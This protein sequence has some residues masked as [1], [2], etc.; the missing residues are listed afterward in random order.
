MDYGSDVLLERLLG[1]VPT[2]IPDREIS[3]TKT[4]E[5]WMHLI[6]SAHKKVLKKEGKQRLSFDP[7]VTPN[8]PAG[9]TH[10]K[11]AGPTQGE[12]GRGRLRPAKMAFTLLAF[13]RGLQILWLVPRRQ[14]AS[15]LLAWSLLLLAYVSWPQVPVCQKTTSSWR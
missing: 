13:L 14:C 3:S 7:W 8:V 2:Y 15:V 5:R 1:L 11:E 9:S 4:A 10:Q 12:G 6:A